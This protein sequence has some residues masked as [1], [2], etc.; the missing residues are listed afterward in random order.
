MIGGSIEGN[1]SQRKEHQI[2]IKSE[3]RNQSLTPTS[4]L[5]CIMELAETLYLPLAQFPYQKKGD[6]CWFC[7]VH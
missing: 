6:T 1:V 5:T 3:E 2:R 4:A 7:R